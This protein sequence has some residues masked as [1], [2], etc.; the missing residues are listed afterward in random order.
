MSSSY[1]DETLPVK[2]ENRQ[3]KTVLE[4]NQLKK[5]FYKND[6]FLGRIFG[7]FTEIQALDGVSFKLKEGEIFGIV[8]ESGCG[9]ST[10]AQTISRLYD[11]TGGEIYFQ[12][13]DISALSG[14]KLKPYRQN[15]QLI[16]QN[17]KS[18]L[19]PRDS[20]WKILNDPLRLRGYPK[21]N[22]EDRIN[23]LLDSV[24]LRYSI[25]DRYPPDLSGGQAQRVAI[26]R[27]LAMDPDLL[28]AD[29]P[30]SAL[31]ASVQAG[32]MEVFKDLRK[33]FDLSILFISHNLKVVRN[34][35][36]RIMVMYLGKPVEIGD[37]NQVI[38]SPQHP[39][40]K[41][42]IGAIP[43]ITK[44]SQSIEVLEGQVP[45]PSNPPRGCSFHPRCP[46]AMD[47]CKKTDPKLEIKESGREASCHLYEHRNED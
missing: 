41:A 2:S 11:P 31:D 25:I 15:I 36:D 28:I 3:Q 34:M 30:T 10:L 19:N 32:I 37:S 17:P 16:F 18:S 12:G 22:R 14:R 13:T 47:E 46:E 35:S 21:E 7:D 8:G 45:D 20:V 6:S 40:T 4:V 1:T 24:G 9:K 27:A 29:E 44:E 38:K 23:K 33:E 39:Y 5:Y 42:L 26:T 43:D